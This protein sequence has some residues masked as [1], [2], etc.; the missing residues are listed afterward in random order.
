VHYV[1]VIA[2]LLNTPEWHCTN[3][4]VHP[5]IPFHAS[6]SSG[7]YFSHYMQVTIYLV[8]CQH[9][10][11]GRQIR[12]HLH[13]FT[14]SMYTNTFR[15]LLFCSNVPQ[16]STK[17]GKKHLP[18]QVL[19]IVREQFTS[20]MFMFTV[21]VLFVPYCVKTEWGVPLNSRGANLLYI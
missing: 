14:N 17:Y 13:A 4:T 20:Y 15:A 10:V 21:S 9:G 3:C 7:S 11:S 18:Y 2:F 5:H 19:L 1:E 6:F 16:F 12:I 8:S